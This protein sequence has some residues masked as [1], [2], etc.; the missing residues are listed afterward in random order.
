MEAKD[1]IVL[2][3]HGGSGRVHREALCNE[4]A[5]AYTQKLT[6]AVSCG[7]EVLINGGSSLEAVET[8]I[9]ILEDSPLFNAGKGAVY[10][11]DEIIEL[12]A[13]IMDGRS[14]QAGSV[15]GVRTI[16]NPISAAKSVL[17]N[18]PFVMLAGAGA[19]QFA[20]ENSIEIVD[21]SWFA[22]AERQQQIQD[23]KRAETGANSGTNGLNNSSKY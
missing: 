7:Y 2:I 8:A 12:D 3:V 4:K 20:A 17:E 10:S 1:K 19:E 14:M 13:S 16:K 15:A 11:N 21:P 6:E 18:S 5:A 23:L 9:K 22:T